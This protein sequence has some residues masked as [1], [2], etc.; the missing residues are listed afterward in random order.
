MAA[1]DVFRRHRPVPYYRDPAKTGRRGPHLPRLPLYRHPGHRQDHLRQDPGQGRQLRAPGERGPLLPVRQLPGYRERQLSGCAG[2]GRRLQQ[3]RGPGPCPAGR[4]HLLPGQREKAGVHRGRG[5]HAVHR[6]L[7]RPAENS[8]GAAGA[9]DVHPG[10]HGAAQGA[11]H[12]PLPVPAVL[13]Q[14]HHPP[15]R[16]EAPGLRGRAGG[17]RPDRRRRGAAEPPGGRRPAGR[18]FPAGPVRGR[19]R[20][21]RC[22]RRAGGAGPGG[23]FA[24]RPADGARAGAGRQGGFAAAEPAVRRRQGRGRG[25]GRA[26]H[27]DERPAAAADCP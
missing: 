16:G 12:H 15:G 17:H 6:R 10:Y 21:H 2:A 9:S 14:A 22:R 26:F 1:Q 27:F 3:R 4:G 19:R 24:D 7:Q 23:Q 20:H 8:G 25:A 18:P 5:P 13:L 11:R